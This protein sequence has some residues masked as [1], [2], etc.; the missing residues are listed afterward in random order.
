VVKSDSIN[1]HRSRESLERE[2]ERVGRER[3]KVNICGVCGGLDIDNKYTFL[4][5]NN[6]R[7]CNK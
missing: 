6:L 3:E 4:L 5:F 2:R 7:E 1:F